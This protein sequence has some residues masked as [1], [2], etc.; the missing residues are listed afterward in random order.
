MYIPLQAIY[1]KVV[2]LCLLQV[3]FFRTNRNFKIGS[4]Q[5]NAKKKKEKKKCKKR[6]KNERRDREKVMRG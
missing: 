5:K 1:R 4:L 2:C 3:I 6:E